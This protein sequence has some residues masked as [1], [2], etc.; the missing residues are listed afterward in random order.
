MRTS[1]KER[2]ALVAREC[3]RNL[4]HE[5][6]GMLEAW[7]GARGTHSLTHRPPAEGTHSAGRPAGR[8]VRVANAA[9]VPNDDLFHVQTTL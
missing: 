7:L 2:S 5:M 6:D 1:G 3:R 9:A 8:L 4:K